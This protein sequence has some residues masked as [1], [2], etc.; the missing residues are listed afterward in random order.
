MDTAFVITWKVPFPG[1][2]Q[3]AL[4]LAAESEEFWG[5]QAADGRCTAPEWFFFP[6]GLGM[7]MVK[8][9]SAVLYE[10]LNSD[11]VRRFLARGTL[12]LQDWQWSFAETG[13]GAERFMAG[14]GAELA[15]I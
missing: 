9:E 3:Q 13:S 10:L 11:E 5:K 4:E 15:N 6:T 14:Y 8:G 7:W 12:L 2:E 1:R